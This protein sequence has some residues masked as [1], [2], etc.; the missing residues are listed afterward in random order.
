MAQITGH[1]RDAAYDEHGV[2]LTLS[3]GAVVVLDLGFGGR[4]TGAG[5]LVVG[6][7]H[8]ERGELGEQHLP[9]CRGFR[10][11]VGRHRR[12]RIAA[13]LCH[14]HPALPGAFGVV[15]FGAVLIEQEQPQLGDVLE[16][17][18]T[19]ADS[20]PDQVE[21]E[22]LTSRL[23]DEPGQTADRVAQDCDVVGVDQAGSLG[24]SNRREHRGQRLTGQRAS[25]PEVG[26]LA[27]ASAGLGGG[28]PPADP[29]DRVP[30]LGT[31]RAWCGVGLELS[32]HPMQRGWQLTRQGLV[33]V[34]HRQQFVAGQ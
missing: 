24:G 17:L 20:D 25:W 33:L 30:R 13:L 23:V 22:L 34:E 5:F 16:F 8:A 7:A 14:R 12:H 26:G 21:L 10:G 29:Q 15:G 6:I 31:Q 19:D 18:G 9:H 3:H 27:E 11:Q 4:A 28:Q 1:Q 2:V 32:E